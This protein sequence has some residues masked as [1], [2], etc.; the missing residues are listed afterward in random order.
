MPSSHSTSSSCIQYIHHVR[1]LLLWIFCH[2]GLYS[3]TVEPGKIFSSLNWFV[4]LF[5]H[6]NKKR[7]LRLLASEVSGHLT[8]RLIGHA[9]LCIHII[10]FG[11]LMFIHIY[12]YYCLS[13]FLPLCSPIF[14]PFFLQPSSFTQSCSWSF[15]FFCFS[16]HRMTFALIL[17]W[18][19]P[20]RPVFLFL[21]F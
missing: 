4:I 1:L 8:L 5:Y 7:N 17:L 18:L 13:M 3:W 20:G 10:W 2:K 6:S 15:V 19:L 12:L 21:F 16:S 9:H 11:V 14:P